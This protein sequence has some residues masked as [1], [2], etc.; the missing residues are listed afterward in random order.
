MANK[1]KFGTFLTAGKLKKILEKVDDDCIISARGRNCIS[2]DQVHVVGVEK[3]D[4]MN[5]VKFVKSITDVYGGD[6]LELNNK[7]K[8]AIIF[9]DND[10]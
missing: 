2:L 3:I 6:N 10:Y 1:Y 5:P 7:S 9:C 4:G 8:Q